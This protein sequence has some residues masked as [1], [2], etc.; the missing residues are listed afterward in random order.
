LRTISTIV[1]QARV[2]N[3]LKYAAQWQWG[4]AENVMKDRAKRVTERLYS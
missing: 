4:D 3:T 1:P 2:L